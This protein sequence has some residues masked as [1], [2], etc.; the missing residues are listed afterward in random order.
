MG[1]GGK[2]DPEFFWSPDAFKRVN[3][4][5]WNFLT[6]PKY[7][8]QNFRT[9]FE[10]KFFNPT[11]SWRGGIKI[12]VHEILVGDPLSLNIIFKAN[13][14]KNKS[15]SW[16]LYLKNWASYGDFRESSRAKSQILKKFKSQNLTQFL[17]LDSEFLHVISIFI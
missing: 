9:Q 15:Q 3:V 2:I 8:K 5:K 7:Q 6:F 10:F 14:N 16:A 12:E 1:G 4:L 13:K 11:P 17:R